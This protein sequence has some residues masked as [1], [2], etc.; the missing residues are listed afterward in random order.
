MVHTQKKE[1]LLGLSFFVVGRVRNQAQAQDG[2]SAF[3][4]LFSAA[5]FFSAGELLQTLEPSQHFAAPLL[6]PL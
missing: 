1:R 5:D 2:P 3:G 4:Q 6:A